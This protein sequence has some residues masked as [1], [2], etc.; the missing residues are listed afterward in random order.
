MISSA[1]DSSNDSRKVLLKHFAARRGGTWLEDGPDPPVGIR[2]SHGPQ[3]FENRGRMMREIVEHEHARPSCHAAPCGG[4][5]RGNPSAPRIISTTFRPAAWPAAIAASAFLTLWPPN[6][7]SVTRPCGSP[8]CVRSNVMRSPS[9]VTADARQSAS[10]DRPN[11]STMQRAPDASVHGFLAVSAEDQPPAPGHQIDKA[12]ER[13]AQRFEI[14]ID[15]RV[16]VLAGCRP[17]RCPADIS[18]TWPSCR[19]TRCRTRRLR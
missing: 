1:P 6:S 2:P 4:A 19:R 14:R 17:R 18:G 16:V 11:V 12:A 3:C 7:G 9:G 13:D 5:R 8:R 15:V 10:A